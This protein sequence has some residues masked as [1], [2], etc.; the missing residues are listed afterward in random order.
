MLERRPDQILKKGILGMMRRTNLR[1]KYIE[2]RL[3]AYAGSDH[4]HAAQLPEAVE[5]LPRHTRKRMGEAHFGLG[6]RYAKEG[7]YQRGGTNN[8]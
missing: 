8:N 5:Q 4:P 3:K 1:H 2:P 7:S 6:S